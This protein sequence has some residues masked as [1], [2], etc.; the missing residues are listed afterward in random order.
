M[1]DLKNLMQYHENN[2]L[3]IIEAQTTFEKVY[4][5]HFLYLQNTRAA[6]LYLEQKN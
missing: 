5:G 6:K 4:G 3:E 2:C 1:I